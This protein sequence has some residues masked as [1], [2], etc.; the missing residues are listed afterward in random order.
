MKVFIAILI[1][2][3]L[4]ACSSVKEQNESNKE[5]VKEETTTSSEEGSFE[6]DTDDKASVE[7]NKNNLVENAQEIT[8]DELKEE[9]SIDDQVKVSGDIVTVA[10]DGSPLDYL[11]LSN[12][13]GTFTVFNLTTDTYNPGD[14]ITVYGNVDKAQDGS[15]MITGIVIETN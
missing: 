5:N 10:N 2:M 12:E 7:E 14:D 11:M 8:A 13:T 15:K 1:L 9:S 3:T 6:V 4:A